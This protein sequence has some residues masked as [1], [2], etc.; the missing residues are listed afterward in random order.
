MNTS[1][2]RSVLGLLLAL[3]VAP[4]ASKAAKPQPKYRKVKWVM[5]I[6]EP[7][8]PGDLWAC[9]NTD[10]NEPERQGETY[11]NLQMQAIDPSHYGIPA[12]DIS[13]GNGDYWRPV[14]LED[15]Y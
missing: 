13:R 5:L 10:P 1:T 15:V 8:C 9:H 11:F 2:R 4:F 14:G 6:D 3:L 7:V 12:K